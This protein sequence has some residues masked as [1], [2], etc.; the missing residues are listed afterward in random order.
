MTSAQSATVLAP[1]T[2]ETQRVAIR[3]SITAGAAL[4]RPYLAMNVAAAFIAGFGLMENSPN[5][6][7][8]NVELEVAQD[9]G[10]ETVTYVGNVYKYYITYKLALEQRMQKDKAKTAV[11][12]M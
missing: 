8:G 11:T 1:E 7:F 12:G 2:T 3:Q 6:W 10:Q 9:I 5:K 4:T